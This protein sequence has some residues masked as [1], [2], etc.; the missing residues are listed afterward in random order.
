MID[1]SEKRKTVWLD[2]D[3]KAL[4]DAYDQSVYAPNFE[5]LNR[6]RIAKSADVRRRLGAPG[7]EPG[8]GGI[9]I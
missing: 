4:D 5:Q 6:R 1:G 3:Q 2:L 9:K 7:F 8:N